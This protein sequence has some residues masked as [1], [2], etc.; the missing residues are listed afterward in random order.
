MVIILITTLN[1]I[2]IDTYKYTLVHILSF[3]LIFSYT[4]N[5]RLCF[6]S[7]HKP[8]LH[9]NSKTS[10]TKFTA[11]IFYTFFNLTLCLISFDRS[12]P[13]I[14]TRDNDDNKIY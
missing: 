11:V 13:P 7:F 2:N 10:H 4:F 6:E 8:I 9:S 1:N 5:I 12:H 3:I 14:T